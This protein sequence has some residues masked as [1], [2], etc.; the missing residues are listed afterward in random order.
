MTTGPNQRLRRTQSVVSTGHFLLVSS[1]SPSRPISSL[2]MSSFLLGLNISETG[3]VREDPSP[4]LRA[5]G[6]C[7]ISTSVAFL[8]NRLVPRVLEAA[9]CRLSSVAFRF[10]FSRGFGFGQV[11]GIVTCHLLSR[12]LTLPCCIWYGGTWSSIFSWLGLCSVLFGSGCL[13]V[14]PSL[15]SRLAVPCPPLCFTSS[16]LACCSQGAATSFHFCAFGSL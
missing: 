3:S 8:R 16:C 5:H 4:P 7:G 2:S 15:Q 1:R 6:V 11:I 10:L 14:L 13:W 12:W 9:T